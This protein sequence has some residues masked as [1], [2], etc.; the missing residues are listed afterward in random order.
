MSTGKKRVRFADTHEEASEALPMEPEP[1]DRPNDAT[2]ESSHVENGEI[3]HGAAERPP[4]AEDVDPLEE[5]EERRRRVG[6]AQDEDLRWANLK[7]VLKGESS[8]LGY[9]AAREAWKMADRCELSDDGLLYFLGEN[10]R[11]GKDRM[12][13]TVLR[14]VVP[15]TKVQEV[16]Q[17]WKEVIKYQAVE[18][19]RRASEHNDSLSRQEKASLP[20]LRVNESSEG[21]PEDAGDTSTP[22]S[23][24]AKSLI[25]PGD[26]VWLSMERVKPGLTKKLAHRWH[27]PFRVK[28]KVEECAYE[29]E[30]PD[31]SGYRFYPVVHVPRLKAV[32]EFGDRPKVRLTRELTD[33]ARLDFV[34]EL[35]PEDSWE[36]TRWQYEVESILDD[37]R[38]METSTRRSVREFLVKWVG[39]HEPTWEPITNLSGGGLLYDYLREKRSLR[40]SKWSKSLT[41]TRNLHENGLRMGIELAMEMWLLNKRRISKMTDRNLNLSRRCEISQDVKSSLSRGSSPKLGLDARLVGHWDRS[42]ST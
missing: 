39:Y 30:L 2:T 8:S 35:L 27:E 10:R 18:K 33:E 3:F 6:R 17:S 22:V 4:S 21:N 26:R 15:T 20:R 28:R 41:R 19:A 14:L 29:L 38:P 36:Q 34:E 42:P 40:G 13:G 9:K 37:G 32:K 16:L 25:E 24:S 23:E 12:N 1:P 5:Q 7:L 11:W 31:R